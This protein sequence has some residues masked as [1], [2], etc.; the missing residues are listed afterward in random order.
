[1]DG[2]NI[3]LFPDRMV[4]ENF[5]FFLKDAAQRGRRRAAALRHEFRA[6]SRPTALCCRVS[7]PIR[8]GGQ[9]FETGTRCCSLRSDALYQASFVLPTSPCSGVLQ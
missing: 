9:A 1:M 3:S 4:I 8:A 5:D 2:R 6:R 7:R